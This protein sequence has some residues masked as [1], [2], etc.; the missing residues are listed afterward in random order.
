MFKLIRIDS[1]MWSR[2]NF[3]DLDS[4]EEFSFECNNNVA[5]ALLLKSYSNSNYKFE[6]IYEEIDNKKYE[7][8]P[9]YWEEE[10]VEFVK[11]LINQNSNIIYTGVFGTPIQS[12]LDIEY[13][14][15]TSYLFSYDELYDLK[16]KK[17]SFPTFTNE[18]DKPE[19]VT[20]AWYF[21]SKELEKRF[22][23]KSILKRLIGVIKHA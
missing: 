6:N 7:N 20:F 22:K 16:Y 23:K 8:V 1:D 15:E 21:K 9:D 2:C 18:I 10:F 5:H 13:S 19:I 14:L 12:E 11:K 4:N 17:L 3:I